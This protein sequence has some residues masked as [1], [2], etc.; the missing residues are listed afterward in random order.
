MVRI[1]KLLLLATLISL[2]VGRASSQ[3]LLSL[4]A[5]QPAASSFQ[6]Y[7]QNGYGQGGN[8]AGRVL[9]CS[10]D[11]GKRRYCDADTRRGVRLSRQISGTACVETKTWGYDNRGIWV[12]R[13]CRAE[14][15]VGSGGNWH[16]AQGDWQGQGQI[17][18]CSSDNG[19][20]NYC[21]TNGDISR[22][23]LSRQL[24][25]S[26]CVRDSTWGV[27][28]RGLW[29]D[30]GCR[31]EFAI[32]GRGNWQNSGEGNWQEG[33]SQARTITCS[34]DDGG[35]NYCSIGGADP[36]NVVMTRQ[37]SDSRCSQGDTWGVDRRG[38]WVDRGCRAEFQVN[39]YR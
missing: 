37:I 19:R 6:A 38:L 20:R 16:G 27:D 15:V 39:G 33:H 13:G 5:L 34:S 11:D 3:P 36:N 25:G 23:T 18:T 1:S 22:I 29:V 9:T 10:S 8:G 30:R 14:F 32:G 35:K 17:V 7:G 12:D 2:S 21:R 31:A 26:S 24:S 28:G 4:P